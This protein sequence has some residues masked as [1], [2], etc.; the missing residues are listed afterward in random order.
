MKTPQAYRCA[1]PRVSVEGHVRGSDNPSPTRP[2]IVRALAASEVGRGGAEAIGS[3]N[4]VHLATTDV[5][6]HIN[7]RSI[8]MIVEVASLNRTAG[9]IGIEEAGALTAFEALA[10]IDEAVRSRGAESGAE[11]SALSVVLGV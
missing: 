9:A 4:P 11:P 6:N 3:D 5:S 8:P 7:S 2:L 1:V 10:R